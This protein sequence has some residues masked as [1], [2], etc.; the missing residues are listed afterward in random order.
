MAVE[1][2]ENDGLA[3]DSK[4]MEYRVRLHNYRRRTNFLVSGEL[5]LSIFGK[6][7]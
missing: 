3:I 2:R 7:E 5:D 6:Y 4:G 1:P